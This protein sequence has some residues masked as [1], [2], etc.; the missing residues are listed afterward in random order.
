MRIMQWYFLPVFPGTRLP[1]HP[2]INPRLQRLDD[3]YERSITLR[4]GYWPSFLWC[5]SL[6]SEVLDWPLQRFHL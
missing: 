5:S 4:Y 2:P 3:A 1:P 6:C